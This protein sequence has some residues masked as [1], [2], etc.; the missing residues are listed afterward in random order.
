M[1]TLTQNIEITYNGEQGY[2]DINTFLT[3]QFHI[4]GIFNEIQQELYPDEKIT[5]KLKAFKEGSF[6]VEMFFMAAVTTYLFNK[7]PADILLKM[8]GTFSDFITIGNLLR[9]KKADKEIPLHDDSIKLEING[10]NNTVI[11]NKNSF[12]IYKS[13]PMI[14]E[15]LNKNFELLDDDDNISGLTIS[16][17]ETGTEII[18]VPKINFQNFV[19][20]NEYFQK[21]KKINPTKATLYIKKADHFPKE[22]YVIWNFIY[23]GSGIK[24]TI[25][26]Q[27]F[28]KRINDGER[29][30]QGDALEVELLIE[31]EWA[32]KLNTYIRSGKYEVLKVYDIV[33]RQKEKKLF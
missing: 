16:N 25:K 32:E 3:S 4:L 8:I 29:F 22:T 1:N 26:D 28:I 13:N 18:T 19:K 9:G 2:I 23:D 5:I 21:E 10:N 31:Q 33:R 11:I 7:E 30:G 17:K 27:D 12:E 20:D 24:A 6:N 14:T 15:A